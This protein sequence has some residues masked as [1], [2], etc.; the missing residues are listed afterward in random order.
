MER[1]A[2]GELNLTPE[3]F[4]GYTVKE[5]D[6]MFEGYIR[7]Q[8]RLEDLFILYCAYPTYQSSMRIRHP[9]SIRKLLAYRRKRP[10]RVDQMDDAR[11][12]HWRKVLK[13]EEARIREAQSTRAES[14]DRSAE[15]QRTGQG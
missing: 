11:A 13:E 3:Q 9:P 14:Q 2:L 8:E 4:G 1:M 10:G 6:A 7:R 15:A 12:D 5:L